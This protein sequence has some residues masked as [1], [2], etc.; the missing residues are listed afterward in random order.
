MTVIPQMLENQNALLKKCLEFYADEN[1]WKLQGNKSL[2]H[3]D[4]GFLAQNT[5]KEV[6]KLEEQN[7]GF[8]DQYDAIVQAQ[9][10]PEQ[11]IEE[12]QKMIGQTE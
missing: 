12:I 2:V 3:A 6:A 7:Q 10:S 11:L 4:N 5:L 1:N 9:T 8:S